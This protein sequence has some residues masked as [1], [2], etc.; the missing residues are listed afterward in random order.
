MIFIGDKRLEEKVVGVKSQGKKYFL[1]T[2]EKGR[3]RLELKGH[4]VQVGE[5]IEGV[6]MG[7]IGK[8]VAISKWQNSMW[9]R[10]WDSQRDEQI[11]LESKQQMQ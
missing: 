5:D 3:K 2:M 10:Q 9:Q 6:R 4:G 8:Q 11:H 7:K 1:V